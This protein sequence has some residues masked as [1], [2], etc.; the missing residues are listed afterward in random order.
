MNYLEE[1]LAVFP[2]PMLENQ[3]ELSSDQELRRVHHSD[4]S[5]VFCVLKSVAKLKIVTSLSY[6]RHSFGSISSL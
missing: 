5:A 4:R 2:N 6:S 1:S 3:L